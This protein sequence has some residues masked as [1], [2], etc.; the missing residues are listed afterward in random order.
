MLHAGRYHTLTVSRISEHGAYLKNDEGDEVLLPNRYTSLSDKVGDTKRVF[1]YHDSENRLVATTEEPLATVGEAT[2]LKVVDKNLHGAFLDWGLHGKDLFL[3]NRNQHGGVMIGRHY[4]VYIYEDSITGRAVATMRLNG[5]INN[6]M[7]TVDVK[8]RVRI[9]IFSESPIGYRV[10]VNDRH[11]GMIY[12][13]QLFRPV[14]IGERT[15]AYVRRITDDNRLDLSLQQEGLSQVRD[16]AQELLDRLEEAG[17]TLDINDDTPPE[18]IH[19]TVG[20]SK[21]VF[22]R[23]VGMLLKSGRIE[24]DDRSIRLIQKP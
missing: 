17:G 7:L 21:K 24:M 12:K 18:V 1:V 23:S 4:T 13:N 3:P 10:I 20:M 14:A 2:Y 16:S 6:D 8:G 15:E 9:M 22:K 19:R 5:F 11:W